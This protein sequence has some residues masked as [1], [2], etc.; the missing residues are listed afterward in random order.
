MRVL[1]F[2]LL[3]LCTSVLSAQ[4][5]NF[6]KASD[7]LHKK[8]RNFVVISES[9][10]ATGTLFALNELWYSDYPRRNFHFKNDNSQ[11]LQMDK[12]GHVMSSYYVGKIGMDVLNWS[13]VSRKDQLIYGATLGFSFLTAVEVMDGF[14][15]EWGFSWGDFASNALGTGILVGQELLWE[16]QRIKLKFSFRNTNFASQRPEVL[17]SNLSEQILKDY[18]G[19]TYWLSANLWSFNKDSNIPKWFNIA[20]GYGAQGMLFGQ[21]NAMNASLQNPYRQF[22]LSFDVD[23]ER[24]PTKSKF[25]K[26]IFS[27]INFIKIPAPTLELNKKQ[28]LK[29]HLLYF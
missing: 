10:L 5:S 28:G 16:E 13:G 1:I 24:I 14:S 27:V 2:F 22:Y 19:Q 17:G 15:S 11:W 7:T 3:S 20:F 23:L 26:S 29:F 18:N 12:F 25:L 21:S 4:K 6:W 8:R 9:V